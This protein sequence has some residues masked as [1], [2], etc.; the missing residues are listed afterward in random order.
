MH[1][2]NKIFIAG[3]QGL[4]GSTVLGKLQAAGYQQILTRSRTELDLTRQ[5]D[6]ENFFSETQP[7]IVFLAAGKVGGIQANSTY[8]ADFIRDNLLIQANVIDAAYRC[9]VQKFVFLG[10][11]CIYPKLAP[12]PLKEDYLLTSALEPTNEP[13]AIAKISGIKMCQAYRRQ[14]G[15]NS[16]CVMPTNL[17]GPHDRFDLLNSHVL[18][19]LLR[20]FHEAKMS[21]SDSVLIWGSGTPRREFLHV[22]DLADACLFLLQQ[23]KNVLDKVSF[24]GIIN[25]G[26]GTDISILELAELLSKIVGFRGKLKFD[27]SKPDGTPQK[28]LD[29]TRLAQLGWNAK[30]SL[31]D[32][33]EQTY[34]WYKKIYNEHP[35]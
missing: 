30:I 23:P 6:V 5:S 31:N 4:V 29:S 11:S 10:S 35:L 3:H 7:E 25:V 27:S 22:E 19:A 18:P 28:L 2:S 8:P 24:D 9:K 20:K 33:I 34:K 12:Q 17:Y 16:I 15:F 1:K 13:Y 26:F 32:G 21:D 14:Y